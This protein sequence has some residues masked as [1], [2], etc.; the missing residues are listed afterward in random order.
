MVS[1]GT[2]TP[3]PSQTARITEPSTPEM[4]NAAA[5]SKSSDM[6]ATFLALPTPLSDHDFIDRQDMTD[7]DFLNHEISLNTPGAA[8]FTPHLGLH[9]EDSAAMQLAAR[10]GQ[11]GILSILLRTG[12]YVDSRDEKGRTPLHQ[13]AIHGHIEA[14]KLLLS[15]GADVKSTD[16]EGTSVIL[17]AVKARCEEM[18]ELLLNCKQ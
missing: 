5:S 8:S 7:T 15:A 2:F 3:Q 13:C 1:T 6:L 12:F 16:A 4:S 14:A 9:W 11:T 10:E 17:A 18:V